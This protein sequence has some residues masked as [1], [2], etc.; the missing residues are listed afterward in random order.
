MIRGNKFEEELQELAR[1]IL[2]PSMY[3]GEK[4]DLIKKLVNDYAQAH[5]NMR[6]AVAVCNNGVRSIRL[7]KQ[8]NI[9][10]KQQKPLDTYFPC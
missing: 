6:D 8:K 1:N 4:G 10:Q 9:L 2:P 3:E 5:E 7:R